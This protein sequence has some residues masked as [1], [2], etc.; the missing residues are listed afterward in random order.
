MSSADPLGVDAAASPFVPRLVAEWLRDEPERRWR[1]VDGA[2]VFVDISGFTAMSERLAV[3]GR[4]GAERVTEIIDG[5]FSQLLREA[6]ELDGSLLKFGGDAL[7]LLFE[8]DDAAR[9]AAAAAHDMRSALYRFGAVSTPA[10]PVVLDMSV[11]VHVGPVD[12]FLVGRSHR[13]LI[14]TGP[15]ATA[16]VRAE[17]EAGAGRILLSP[18]AVGALPDTVI[19]EAIGSGR[20]LD[21]R[22]P[23]DRR[24]SSPIEPSSSTWRGVSS[25]LRRHLVDA[26]RER[27]EHRRAVVGFVHFE[28]T[29]EVLADGGHEALALA[30][31]D[32]VVDVQRAVDRRQLCLLASDV[33]ENGG[34][35][36][37]TAGVPAAHEDDVDRLLLT[38][39]EI[40][41]RDRDI[42]VRI[43]VQGGALFAGEVGPHFRRTYTVM[44]DVVN[45]AARVM[46]RAEQNQV[47]AT[48]EVL[49]TAAIP[50]EVVSVAPFA[51]KGKAEPLIAS[52]VIGNRDADPG[53]TGGAASTSFVGRAAEVADLVRGYDRACDGRGS[54]VELLGPAGVGKTE[55]LRAVHD[56][57]PDSSMVVLRCLEST[58]DVAYRPV[59]AAMLGAFDIPV[60]ESA[61]SARARLR[62]AVGDE[63]GPGLEPIEVA[64][65]L[66]PPD[67]DLDAKSFRIDLAAAVDRLLLTFFADGLLLVIENAQWADDGTAE[68]VRALAARSADRPYLIAVTART[69]RPS[70]G[71]RAMAVSPLGDFEAEELARLESG[72]KLLPAEAAELARRAGGNPLFIVELVRAASDRRGADDD[73]DL[74]ETLEGLLA[75]RIDRTAPADRALLRQLAVLGDDVDVDELVAFIGSDGVDFE[76]TLQRLGDLLALDPERRSVRFRQTLLHAAAYQGLPFRRR[77]LLHRL[78]ADLLEERLDDPA[79]RAED[80][81]RHCSIAQDRPRAW[82]YSLLAA[83]SAMDRAGFS[84]AADFYGQAIDSARGLRIDS[85]SRAEAY[86]MWGHSSM[87]VGRYSDAG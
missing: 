41:E 7:L 28:G 21:A 63:L 86:R 16:V 62:A 71:G 48:D 47:L 59:R 52:Q 8:G 53:L 58:S 65:G 6:Y 15:G 27:S 77:R 5:A 24:P 26:G 75:E 23:V 46:S 18:G 67:G 35:L 11:G 60:N 32:L 17:G 73:A 85:A 64:L 79:V 83:E 22:P 51:V 44:G 61:E 45:T 82:K 68:L 38:M 50:Y 76:Q 30:L 87:L 69:E 42:P 33:D 29:D 74:P 56:I 78:A 80:L 72:D 1:V 2:L 36:I 31:D 57:R 40:V 54:A 43:G 55:I 81:S 19:G 37:V 4:E 49:A 25:A 34:K 39:L 12:L 70:M 20:S 3:L 66:R 84:A 9:R 13:E 14:V 10:G